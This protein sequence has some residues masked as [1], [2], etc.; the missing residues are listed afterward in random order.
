MVNDNNKII[1]LYNDYIF[2]FI[3]KYCFDVIA[4]NDMCFEVVDENN[5]LNYV[6]MFVTSLSNGI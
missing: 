3:T 6:L 5:Q 4:S 1:H 2:I